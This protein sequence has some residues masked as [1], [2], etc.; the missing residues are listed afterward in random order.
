MVASL[1]ASASSLLCWICFSFSGS[2]YCI[3]SDSAFACK[4]WTCASPSACLICCTFVVS[5]SS[6]AMRTCFCFSSVSTP[7]R[8]FS[9]CFSSRVCVLLRQLN[10]PQNHFFHH[11]SVG[12]QLLRDHVCRFLTHFLA[13]RRKN[14][15]HRVV[16]NQFPPHARRDRRSNLLLYRRGKL[17]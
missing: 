16:R 5:A 11:D 14:I 7:M 1:R 17:L 6:S 13:L 15:P 9:C 4:T 2:V 3:A 10:V 12:R 8:S